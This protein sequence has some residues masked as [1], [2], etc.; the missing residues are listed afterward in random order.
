VTEWQWAETGPVVE[1][2]SG[3]AAAKRLRRSWTRLNGPDVRPSDVRGRELPQLDDEHRE[4]LRALGY[5]DAA[6]SP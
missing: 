6:D 4:R 2:P 5:V 1:A 3:S